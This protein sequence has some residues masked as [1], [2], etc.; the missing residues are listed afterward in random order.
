[1]LALVGMVMAQAN[2]KGT[3]NASLA[4]GLGPKSTA[5]LNDNG[6]AAVPS[7]DD[8][9]ADLYQSIAKAGAPMFITSD[10]V[11]HS[12]HVLFDYA[13][14]DAET[15]YFYG[16]LKDLAEALV[17]FETGALKDAKTAEASDALTGNI[18][19]LSVAAALL[20]TAFAIPKPVDSLVAAELKL[21]DAH[22]GEAVS[23]VM[24][25][26]EDY[27]QY[28]PR[29]HYTRTELLSRYFKAMMWFGR[30]G[31]ALKP[32]N[33]DQDVQQG[34]ELTY[35]ALLLCDALRQTRVAGDSALKVWAAIYDP[36]VLLVGRSDDLNAGD[37]LK[38]ADEVLGDRSQLYAG[39]DAQQLDRFIARAMALPGPRIVSQVVPDTSNPGQ[40][41]KGF[42]FMGQRFIPDSYMFQELVYTKVGTQQNPRTMPKGLDVMAVL[43]SD[44]ARTV[45]DNVYHENRFLN[46]QAQ[47]D[48]LTAEFSRLTLDEWNQNV[49]F[50]WLYALKLQNEPVAKSLHLPRLCFQT[51]YADK[52]LVA[53]CGSWTQLRHD[54]IL[55]AKQ[56]YTMLATSILPVKRPETRIVFVEPKPAVYLQVETLA[57]RMLDGLAA[58]EVLSDDIKSRLNHL[59]TLCAYLQSIAQKEINGI[60]PGS[61]EINYV[62]QV[63][64][65]MDDFGAFPGSEAYRNDEDKSM[66]TVADV[67]T[68]PNTGT[69]LEEAV[70]RP[71]ELYIIA[72]F[73]GKSYVMKGGMFSYYEFTK[74]MADRM[75]DAQWQQMPPPPMPEWTQSFVTQ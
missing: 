29:G 10:C 42:R 2:L 75:T 26:K 4:T 14:R 41:T 36:T 19:Y 3:E 18:A 13:L 66:A 21:I 30:I 5:A 65:I 16:D 8:Q 67:H 61:D 60:K 59:K 71:L 54:T 12:F 23:P 69:V 27:S 55:Y 1:M 40:V 17:G 64:G 34:R 44:R 73:D 58:H 51:A 53:T 56:S 38:L 74:P 72:N 11:L 20:D 15:R 63:G 46:Y 48:K 37:Y 52:C 68:D 50:G 70:G 6:I 43:G 35:R 45:L 32:G 33:T 9:L 57:G 28:V 25:F 31:F 62:W 49:Y 47:L 24:G 39:L 7:G 22:A